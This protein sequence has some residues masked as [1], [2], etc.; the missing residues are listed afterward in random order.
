[1]ASPEFD[2]VNVYAT[3]VTAARAVERFPER[4]PSPVLR[5]SL[6]GELLYANA[7]SEPIVSALGPT[8]NK[9]QFVVT[10]GMKNIL[11]GM[12]QHGTSRLI[13]TATFLH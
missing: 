12:K 7:A 8:D 6:A 9:S 11:A 5:V 1:M 4:N 3:D 2:F 10:R 13:I